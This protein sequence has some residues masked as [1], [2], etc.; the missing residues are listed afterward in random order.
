MGNIVCLLLLAVWSF[1]LKAIP[2][3]LFFPSP[4]NDT[5]R[6]TVHVRLWHCS[7]VEK[8]TGSGKAIYIY[9]VFLSQ[10]NENKK[11]KTNRRKIEIKNERLLCYC[12]TERDAVITAPIAHTIALLI[13]TR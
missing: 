1:F 7:A 9:I 3:F 10:S 12:N 5:V 4:V 13:Q 8:T 6:N 11:Q 2:Y